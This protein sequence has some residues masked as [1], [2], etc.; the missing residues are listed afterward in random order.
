MISIKRNLIANYYFLK[1]KVNTERKFSITVTVNSE[2]GR[3][4]STG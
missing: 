1:E 4:I 2:K 3:E